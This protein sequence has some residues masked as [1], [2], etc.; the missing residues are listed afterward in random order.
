MW[1]W[2]SLIALICWSGSDLF[3]KI[4]CQDADDKYSHLK[5]VMAVGLVMGLHAAYEIFINGTE[6]NGSIILTYLPV[7]LLYISSMTIGYIGLRYI[8]LSISSPICNS[9]GALVAVLAYGIGV[10]GGWGAVMENAR[11][12]S[13]YLTMT[14][15]HDAVTGGATSYSLLD[16]VSTMAWGLGYFGMPHILL[17]F[18]A[19]E[20]EKK[21]VLSRRIASVWVVIAMTASIVIGVVGLGM[22]KAGALEFLSGSSSETLIVRIASLIAQHG[23]LAAVLAGLILAGI[24]AATMSTADS[25]M[26]AAASSVSQNILQEF[27][28]MKLTEKQSLFAAR[29]TII[30]VSVVGVVLARDP[31]S[32]VFGIV[33]FAWAGFGGAFG[34]V[35]LCALFWKRCNW[36]GALAGMLCGGLM[37]FVWKYLISPL[38]GVFGI[39]ELLPAFLFS[40]A[41]CVVVSLA[42]PAPGADIEA[43]FEAAK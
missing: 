32:S 41:A 33:S 43:E 17:R 26:L 30:C 6:I 29:L 25:Q 22:T 36:Q 3:S 23:V 35:V 14:A 1:F 42:T 19:I 27:G 10:A 34:A 15:S 24:L 2:F 31:D 28:H 4:G 21:L 39:Y 18:M 37:V 9:S 7:S 5:M 13:G 8:E 16:I 12:L 11:S 20:D 38:G 40:L